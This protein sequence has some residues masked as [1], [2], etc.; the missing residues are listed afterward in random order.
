MPRRNAFSKGS[1][2]HIYNRGA[3]RAPIFFSQENYLYCLRLIKKYAI[4]YQIT[5]IAYCLMPN[6]YHFL[7]RQDGD[8]PISK[9]INVLFNAYVQAINWQRSRSGTLFEG[10]FKHKLV[11]RDEYLIHL[12]RYIHANPVKAGL[13]TRLEDWPYSNY[14]EWIGERPGKLVD[15]DFVDAYFP[16]RQNYTEFVLDYLRNV[17]SLPKDIQQYLFD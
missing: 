8:I 7:L 6:H 10:R 4:T 2:F 14:P 17:E 12:C 13:V 15:H 5:L 3:N 1:T 9:F 16:E 11:D